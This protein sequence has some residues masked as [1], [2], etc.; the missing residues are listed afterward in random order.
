MTYSKSDSR[1]FLLEQQ[2]YKNPINKL[3]EYLNQKW[4]LSIFNL[5]NEK[6]KNSTK[7]SRMNVWAPFSCCISIPNECNLSWVCYP[8][9]WFISAE[10]E[11]DAVKC[12]SRYWLL[13]GKMRAIHALQWFSRLYPNN[14]QKAK[15]LI[16]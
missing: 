11:M 9:Q 7:C 4:K 15:S 5:Q 16:H 1:H 3:F 12:E 10:S 8:L 13:D 6:Q 14:H 2:T